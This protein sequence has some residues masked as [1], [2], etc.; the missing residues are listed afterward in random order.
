MRG[1][2]GR[3]APRYDLANHLLSG[4]LDRLW[5]APHRAA[6]SATSWTARTRAC[7]TSAAAPATCCSRSRSAAAAP[8]L[9]SDFCHPMLV[10]ARDAR[11]P[12]RARAVFRV[13]RAAPARPRCVARPDH[14]RVRLPQPRQLRS[15]SCARCA[16]CCVR[17]AWPRF[18]SSR[19][20][21]NAA[22]RERSTTSIPGASSR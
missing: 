20:R 21:R 10:A 4:N 13:R 18:S 8:V 22:L 7:S 3:I 2:F 19:S 11:S 12:G 15:R 9:G 6:A 17:A 5:R 16:A 1:M 14:R